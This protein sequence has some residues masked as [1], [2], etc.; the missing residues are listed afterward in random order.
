MSSQ[1]K[2]TYENNVICVDF[3]KKK[4]I[5]ALQVEI[6]QDALE[7][8]Y[9]NTN[10]RTDLEEAGY[11]IPKNWGHNGHALE[12]Y[13][14][15]LNEE[16]LDIWYEPE[17]V[18]YLRPIFN[19]LRTGHVEVNGQS[20]PLLATVVVA[21][22]RVIPVITE[23]LEDGTKIAY[24]TELDAVAMTDFAIKYDPEEIRMYK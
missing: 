3:V 15:V 18:A 23:T 22:G 4:T 16:L 6:L 17:V 19:R 21:A 9:S 7:E 20:I 13:S 12:S 24:F 14:K 2:P 5:D 1:E 11:F 10:L 8:V